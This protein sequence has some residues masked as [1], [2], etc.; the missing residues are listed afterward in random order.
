MS[1]LVNLKD[2]AEARFWILHLGAILAAFLVGYLVGPRLAP[3]LSLLVCR[4]FVA[5]A[6][7]LLPTSRWGRYRPYLVIGAL[8]VA[9]LCWAF[10]PR[11]TVIFLL[12]MTYF[13]LLDLSLDALMVECCPE[14]EWLGKTAG[15]GW[16]RSVGLLGGLM[17]SGIS[18]VS[19]LWT[20]SVPL[21]VLAA[22]FALCR[23]KPS[24]YT[25]AETPRLASVV[26][27]LRIWLASKE[28]W[29][30]G[31]VLGAASI[32]AGVSGT[33]IFPVVVLSPTTIAEWLNDPWTWTGAGLSW[34]M[35]AL[36]FERISVAGLILFLYPLAIVSAWLGG[37]FGWWP[38]LPHLLLGL[39]TLT[40]YRRLLSV[41]KEK[42]DPCL[43]AAIPLTLWALGQL[44][45][46]AIV[47]LWP[48]YTTAVKIA[49]SLAMAVATVSI[50]NRWRPG[51]RITSTELSALN[52][53]A[54]S[55]RHG[56]RAFD[57]EAAPNARRKTRSRWLIRLWYLV[58]VRFPVTLTLIALTSFMLTGVW[59][60][61]EQKGSW[62][63]RTRGAW[64]TLQTELFLTSLT[65]RLEEEMLASSYVPRDFGAF[66]GSAFQ[67]NGR[68]MQDRDF[69]GTPLYF[70]VL[71]KE[72]RIV[73]AG[74][75]KKHF[76]PDDI[77]R[78]A[79][80]PEGV[81]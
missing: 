72:I 42:I 73:S 55:E 33:T 59:H 62:E 48:E 61:T 37:P 9:A 30:A 17:A 57:F 21:L 11:G 53:P 52:R 49:A 44:L 12:A 27:C 58:T 25:E 28:I 2:S 54:T 41:Q 51:V 76:T 13:L 1:R 46:E 47:S 81:R 16:A 45:G 39:A 4:P 78:T 8:A 18:A 6:I 70:Q 24:H 65:Q 31:L 7:T 64:L 43:R 10:P 36:V 40:A 75:D 77:T 56:D 66:I 35:L 19:P 15:L 14:E 3:F 60:V 26:D 50:G 32:L 80:K 5:I 29:G 20:V 63:R 22:L 23:E 71:P 74:P 68:S 79:A 67:L 69:W 38:L 34:V